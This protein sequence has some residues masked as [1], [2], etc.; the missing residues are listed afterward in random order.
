[1][2]GFLFLQEMEQ[3]EDAR[4]EGIKKLYLRYIEVNVRVNENIALVSV[5]VSTS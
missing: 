3:Q 5:H 4:F 1:M 2:S